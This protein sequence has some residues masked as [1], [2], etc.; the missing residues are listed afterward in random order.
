MIQAELSIQ[1]WKTSDILACEFHLLENLNF[2]LIVFHPH[3]NLERF[4]MNKSF[5]VL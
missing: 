1:K 4:K 5:Y 2:D 3:A